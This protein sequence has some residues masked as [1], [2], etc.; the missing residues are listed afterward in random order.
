LSFGS[1]RRVSWRDPDVSE[2][3]IASF[4]RVEETSRSRWQ[5]AQLASALFL[6][7]LMEAI[8]ASEL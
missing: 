1:Y 8:Y 6:L 7:G 3:H 5:A 4:F 2:E